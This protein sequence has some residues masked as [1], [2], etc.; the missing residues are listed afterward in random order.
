M[1][2]KQAAVC[3]LSHSKSKFS[4]LL[5]MREIGVFE[6]KGQRCMRRLMSS[7]LLVLTVSISGRTQPKG[8]DIQPPDWNSN[9]KLPELPDINADPHIVEVNLDARIADVDL[10]GK[11]VSV[12]TYG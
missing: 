5:F 7:F 3:D 4:L 10:G 1:C 8:A 2:H 6:P 12:W 9:L 11:K